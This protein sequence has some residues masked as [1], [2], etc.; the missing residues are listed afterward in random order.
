MSKF[1]HPEKQKLDEDHPKKIKSKEVIFGC[2]GTIGEIF[3]EEKIKEL[4]E[5]SFIKF[6]FGNDYH[7]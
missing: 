3:P 5:S 7:D 6:Y 1:R 2:T 4:E